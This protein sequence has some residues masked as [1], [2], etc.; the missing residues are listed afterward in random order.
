MGITVYSVI[1]SV[2][3]FNIALVAAFI[4]RRS[5][6]FL[7][8]HTVSFLLF[9]V[10]L[11]MFRLLTPIDLDRAYIVR[12][13]HVIPAIEDLL[14]RTVAGNYTICSLLLFIWALGTI[15]ILVRDA[16][17]QIRFV[18]VSR[19]YPP[20]DRRDLLDLAG[21]YGSNFGLLVSGSISRP[22]T[23]GLFRPVIY[24]PDIELPEEQWRTVLRHEVQHIRSHDEAKKLFFLAIQAL[25]WWNPLAHISRK[26]ID[27]I[28]ELQ[29]DAKVTAGMSEEEVDD[30]LELLKTLK[31][32]KSERPIPAGASA[33]VW[34]QKELEARFAALLN[35]G[36]S[37]RKHP[38]AA[39]YI[40]LTAA[41]VLSYFVIV[42]PYRVAT[43]E[44][45]VE[46]VTLA[47]VDEVDE[48]IVYSSDMYIVFENNEYYLY[49]NGVAVSDISED[50][51]SGPP[52]NTLP[53]LEDNK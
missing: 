45:F 9:M 48:G 27:T 21:E 41:F 6:S 18:R 7:A 12:S 20:S 50:N 2:V 33:L 32:Q 23:A 38:R 15:A 14:N 39:A 49:V 42:Q 3:F 35:R 10:L 4:M 31:D 29:C 43:E 52:F 40:V 17:K 53:I 28:I 51:L 5:S 46:D 47:D 36:F 24:L 34:N 26:E 16:V 11:G 30:Y 19:N 1:I 37:G 44:K 13:N 22:Y 8:R 25:F